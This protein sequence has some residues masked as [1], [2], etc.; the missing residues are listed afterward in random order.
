MVRGLVIAALAVSVSPVADAQPQEPTELVIAEI[1][2]AEEAVDRR[3]WR[4]ARRALEE[5]EEIYGRF[6]APLP[7]VEARIES[8]WSDYNRGYE[9]WD[10]ATRHAA[11]ALDLTIE[12][13]GSDLEIGDA[14]YDLGYVAY[15][16]GQFTQAQAAFLE[17]MTRYSTALPA[18]SARRWRANGWLELASLAYDFHDGDANDDV[19]SVNNASPARMTDI[20]DRALAVWLPN[21]A[22]IERPPVIFLPNSFVGENDGFVVV[23]FAID[24]EGRPV[25]IEV[26][27]SYPGDLYVEGVEYGIERGRADPAQVETERAYGFVFTVVQ[28]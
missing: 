7:L 27:S 4:Q 22:W 13:Q 9:R 12:G 24:A 18:D 28:E 15:R 25:D 17:A 19:S 2:E 20:P 21:D 10:D 6:A 16:A 5:A 8:G 1:A 11:R 23:R 14:A 26:M 3:R